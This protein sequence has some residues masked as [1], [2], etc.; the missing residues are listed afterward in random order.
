[1]MFHLLRYQKHVS[2]FSIASTINLQI[3]KAKVVEAQLKLLKSI[4]GWEKLEMSWWRKCA[5]EIFGS[6]RNTN[7]R[8]TRKWG[9]SNLRGRVEM[10]LFRSILWERLLFTVIL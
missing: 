8:G 9:R 4:K 10:L 7:L 3:V 2:K 6:S 5:N 1:M